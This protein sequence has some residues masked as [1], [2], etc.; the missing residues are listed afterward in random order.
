MVKGWVVFGR[1][2]DGAI[3]MTSTAIAGLLGSLLLLA[4][5]PA[6]ASDGQ[7]PALDAAGTPAEATDAGP[8][9]VLVTVSM[10]DGRRIVF[11]QDAGEDGP[12]STGVTRVLPDGSRISYGTPTNG[13]AARSGGSGRSKAKSSGRGG[14]GSKSSAGGGRGSS[15]GGGK[16][17]SIGG[18][19]GG[20]GGGGSAKASGSS[21]AGARAPFQ[22]RQPVPTI[23]SPR[24]DDEGATGGQDVRFHDAGI[25]AMVIG[26]TVFIWGADVVQSTVEFGLVEGERFAFDGAIARHD[27]PNQPSGSPL[28]SIEQMYAPLKLEYDAGEVVTLSMHSRAENPDSPDREIRSWTFRVR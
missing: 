6:G 12:G 28:S 14:G 10:P 7:D 27:R 24:Y 2:S 8:A 5:T 16:S 22:G 3:T 15:G 25:S 23:G 19:G 20:G 11:E 9:K 13:R 26:R 1:P 4:G 21:P 17:A 18:G